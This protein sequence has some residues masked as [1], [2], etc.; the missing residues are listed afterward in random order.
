MLAPQR[1]QKRVSA[2]ACAPHCGQNA[3]ATVGG[4]PG[5]ALGAAVVVPTGA[6][7]GGGA[8]AGVTVLAAISRAGS[9]F[10]AFFDSLI[11]F[12]SALPPPGSL[13]PP[14]PISAITR[15]MPTSFAPRWGNIVARLAFCHPPLP[16]RVYTNCRH[17]PAPEQA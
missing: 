13:P 7:G 6:V 17:R 9:S 4:T 12:P 14:N 15:I 10:V 2:A 16:W 5:A 3:P 8:G 1:A 11:P